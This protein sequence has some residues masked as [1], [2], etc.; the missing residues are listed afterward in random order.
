MADQKN[1]VEEEKTPFYV[2]AGDYAA[3]LAFVFIERL[4]LFIPHSM[5][6]KIGRNIGKLWYQVD[7]VHRRRAMSNLRMAFSA[8]KTP[9]EIKDICYKCFLHWG[10]VM[11]DLIR[12]TEMTRENRDKYFV[13]DT[14]V[15]VEKEYDKMINLNRGMVAISAHLGSQEMLVGFILKWG[16]GRENIVTKRINICRHSCHCIYPLK[17]LQII[18]I[19]SPYE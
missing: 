14:N 18:N 11:V 19:A 2:K 12:S 4:L 16:V 1:T 13:Y 9:R 10:E 15:D 17:L 5:A 8:E 6:R 3:Y 7:G